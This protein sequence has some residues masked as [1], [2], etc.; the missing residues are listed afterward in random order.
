MKFV[1]RRFRSNP[2][3]RRPRGFAAS[4]A[5]ANGTCKLGKCQTNTNLVTSGERAYALRMPSR[6]NRPVLLI[7]SRVKATHVTTA[8][9]HSSSSL[10]SFDRTSLSQGCAF[11]RRL[12][13]PSSW[14]EKERVRPR[15]S[16][17]VASQPIEARA[18]S[19]SGHERS[20]ETTARARRVASTLVHLFQFTIFGH[21]AYSSQL[22]P[23]T[24]WRTSFAYVSRAT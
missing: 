17:S 12:A 7:S 21:S 10:G 23:P 2:T 3:G 8:E 15:R 11:A 6:Q 16:G 1:E 19:S 22:K 14:R 9:S 18:G 24:P 5:A 4:S 13:I 20:S